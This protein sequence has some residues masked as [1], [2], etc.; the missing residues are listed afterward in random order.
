MK[1]QPVNGKKP[2]KPK[3]EL[4]PTTKSILELVRK[5]VADAGGAWE[6][7]EDDYAAFADSIDE[8]VRAAAREEK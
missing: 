1:G 6:M 4:H 2:D 7:R 5:Y 3:A 8:A